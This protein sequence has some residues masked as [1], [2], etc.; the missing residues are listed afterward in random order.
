MNATRKISGIMGGGGGNTN[1]TGM[2]FH[3]QKGS[4]YS[5]IWWEWQGELWENCI[6]K[7]V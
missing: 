3:G 1:Q 7:Y 4:I 2:V 6:V 5:R